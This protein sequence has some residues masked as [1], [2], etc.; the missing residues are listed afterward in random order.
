MII[1]YLL[2]IGFVEM[3]LEKCIGGIEKQNI[4]ARMTNKFAGFKETKSHD[5]KQGNKKTPFI[6]R[7]IAKKDWFARA[8]ILHSQYPELFDEI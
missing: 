4:K 1:F 6:N 3:G 8:K 2:K 5:I 7:E